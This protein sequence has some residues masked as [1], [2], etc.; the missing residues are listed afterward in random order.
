MSFNPE[1]SADTRALDGDAVARSFG[2]ASGS[3]NQAAALQA[4]ARTELLSRLEHFSLQPQVIL[5]LGCGTGL[6][7]RALKQRFPGAAILS[8]DL[9]LPMLQEAREEY[10]R[11][12]SL[13]DRFRIVFGLG[14][15][16]RTQHVVG[17]A[18]ALPVAS[19]SVQLV[20]SNLM[21][22]WCVPPDAVFSEVRRVLAPGGL[23]LCSTF[24]PLTL[25]ELRTAWAAVDS[26]PH[27][28]EFID[29]HDLGSAMSRAGLVEPV[30]DV[31]RHLREYSGVRELLRELTSLGARNAL[32][33]RRRSL[34]GKRRWAA[35]MAAYPTGSSS[36][37]P[38]AASTKIATWEL[39]YASAFAPEQKP[40]EALTEAPAVTP[41]EVRVP[42]GTLRRRAQRDPP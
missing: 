18:A 21:L 31:D 10:R 22:Q 39:V 27:V 15:Q 32:T 6:A 38:G 41:G 36:S 40:K 11:S 33:N 4:V 19:S 20:F 42:I 12:L 25:Q 8:V 16:H 35:M 1:W 34:T 7:R 23:F 5:D 30:L 2:R 13:T 17:A 28:N 14:A 9:A 29:M 26:E 24:G 37:G 3:Y